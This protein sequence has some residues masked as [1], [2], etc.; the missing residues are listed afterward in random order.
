MSKKRVESTADGMVVFY[1]G[2]QSRKAGK[3]VVLQ[4]GEHVAID[5]SHMATYCF[6]DKEELIDDITAV[7]SGVRTADRA[8]IRRHGKAWGR[9]LRKC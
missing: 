8:F 9:H 2:K 7:L 6:S 4:L 5:A 1:E 3:A